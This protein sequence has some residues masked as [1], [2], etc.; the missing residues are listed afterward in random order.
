[1]QARSFVALG[2]LADSAQ[3][4]TEE[5]MVQVLQALS[6]SLPE[7]LCARLSNATMTL[8][9]K[10]TADI[11]TLERPIAIIMCLT[12]LTAQLTADSVFFSRMFWV[13]VSL[14]QISE[15]NIF[16][17][18]LSL[19]EVALAV[20]CKTHGPF[21]SASGLHS[22]FMTALEPI[23]EQI[24]RLCLMSRLSFKTDFAFAVAGT[25]LKGLKHPLTKSATQQVLAQFLDAGLAADM[26]GE[27]TAPIHAVGSE[28]LGYI[29]SLLH[30][31]KRHTNPLLARMSVRTREELFTRQL[32][33]DTKSAALFMTTLVTILAKMEYEQ[34][35]VFLYGMLRLAVAILPDVFPV[36][37]DFIVPKMETVLATSRN[38]E[39][40]SLIQSIMYTMVSAREK[41][42]PDGTAAISQAYLSEIGFGG[43]PHSADFADVSTTRQ[44]QLAAATVTIIDTLVGH[45]MAHGL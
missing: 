8:T 15:V 37:Y 30:T 40:V 27:L 5:L 1:M 39:I 34:V 28:S 17:A 36:V 2:A 21:P 38:M 23:D 6:A 9:S 7:A 45:A 43:L 11:L 41:L 19:L 10:P 22:Y 32:L 3:I 20:V 14:L 24:N 25:L 26:D 31:D 29:T 4:V 16:S 44:G 12:K 13:A 42:G 18:A 33:P 35:Q